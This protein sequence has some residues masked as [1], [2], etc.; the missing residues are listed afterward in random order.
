[1][2]GKRIPL[3]TKGESFYRIILLDPFIGR[4]GNCKLDVNRFRDVLM[5]RQQFLKQM[6]SIYCRKKK[7]HVIILPGEHRL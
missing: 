4:L 3:S 7:Y 2:F 5:V 1:M 6:L